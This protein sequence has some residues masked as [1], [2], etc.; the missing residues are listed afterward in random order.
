MEKNLLTTPFPADS[1]RQR[2]AFADGN[3]NKVFDYIKGGDIISRLLDA[4]DNDYTWEVTRL[5]LVTHATK[6]SAVTFWVCEG[7]LTLPGL[8]TRS[9]IGTHQAQDLECPKAAETDAFKRAAVKFGVA[10]QL[11][12]DL[13]EHIPVSSPKRGEPQVDQ[14]DPL[15]SDTQ[16]EAIQAFWQELGI[17]PYPIQGYCQSEAQAL[18]NQLR[19]QVATKRAAEKAAQ[20]GASV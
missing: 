13:D 10:L 9:G 15:I 5:E 1:V 17:T 18:Y 11:Y 6:N 2:K 3:S 7:K 14:S 20:E 8:G 4:T 16:K 19:K 12:T